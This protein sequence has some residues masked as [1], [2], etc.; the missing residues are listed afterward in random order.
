MAMAQSLAKIILHLVFSTKNRDRW[1]KK[2]IQPELF[3]YLAVICLTFGCNAYR[4]GGTEDHIHIACTLP[5]TLAVSKLLE[6]IKKS[7]SAWVKNQNDNLRSFAWQAGY[8]AVSIGESQLPQLIRYIENQNNHHRLCS[9]QE[10]FVDLLDRYGIE[11]D[12]R[13]LW[14]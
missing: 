3:A 11:Y 13:Y 10:E 1:L 7:S 12:K 14:D 2:S 6:E 4:V 8:G 9:F 5:R